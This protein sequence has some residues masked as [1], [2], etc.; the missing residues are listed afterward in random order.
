MTKDEFLKKLE[1]QLQLLNEEERSDILSE[2]EQHIEMKMSNG[3]TEEEAIE[4]FGDPDELIKE[5]L[6]AYHLNTDYSR[7][8][9]IGKTLGYYI[10][11]TADFL[12]NLASALL[13]MN[14]HQLGQIFIKSLGVLFFLFI[15]RLLLEL[16]GDVLYPLISLFPHFIEQPLRMILHFI[17]NL[18]FFIFCIYLIVFFIQKYILIDYQAPEAPDFFSSEKNYDPVFNGTE[19]FNSVKQKTGELSDTV[20]ERIHRERPP[21]EDR[22]NYGSTLGAFCLGLVSVIIKF[23]AILILIPGFFSIL[24]L[25]IACGALVVFIFQGF[26][27]FGMTLIAI[28]SL[29]VGIACFLGIFKF[30]FGGAES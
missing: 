28:G 20:R 19:V 2:Y 9:N 17:I 15:C 8:K 14:R 16:C 13:S 30:V 10:H 1:L 27:I 7:S 6:E 23:L 5:I 22:I 11:S 12:T 4:D 29:L 24:G 26:S 25:A 3:L 21:H 18:I